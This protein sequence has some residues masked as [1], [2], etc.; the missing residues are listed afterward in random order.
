MKDSK[1]P[2]KKLLKINTCN[3]KLLFVKIS[4]YFNES[5]ALSHYMPFNS[6]N[7]LRSK[8]CQNIKF[9]CSVFVLRSSD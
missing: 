9:L 1:I 5:M 4:H 7:N 8:T 2:E 6:K 3:L